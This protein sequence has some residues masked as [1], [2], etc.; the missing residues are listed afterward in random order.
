MKDALQEAMKAAMRAKDQVR[1]NTI[2]AVIAAVKYEEIEKKVEP[3]PNDGIVA[4]VQREMKKRKEELEFA[5]Q[6]NRPELLDQLKLEMSVLES[7]MPT[8]I[9]PEQVE[10]FLV[11]FKS[12]NPSGNMGLAM[13]AIKEAYAGQYDSKLASDLAKKIFS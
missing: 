13:K 4:I 11:D 9:T 6:A 5:L 8:Q 7:F 2:R 1:L 3:L 12:K 10:G